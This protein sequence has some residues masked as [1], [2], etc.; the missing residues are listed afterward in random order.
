MKNKI[1]PVAGD[2]VVDRL[3]M[4]DET[5]AM[6]ATEC[7]VIIN[8]AASVNFDDP[9]LDAIQINYAGC[10]RMLE[11]AKECQH[12]DVFC[13][14]STAYTNSNK[15]GFISESIHDLE[16]GQDPDEL[17][18]GII[19]MGPQAV[20]DNE[21]KIIGAYPNTYTFT[22]SMAER[23]V[24][25]N[26]GNLRVAIV[27]PSIIVS[28]YDEPCQGWTD[29][30]AASGGIAYTLHAGLL[31]Y[32]KS[33]GA[34]IV[35]LIPC[36]FVTNM[37]IALSCYTAQEPTPCLNVMHA[38]TSQK[39]PLGFEEFG[40]Y[41]TALARYNPYHRQFSK[42]FYVISEDHNTFLYYT[43]TRETIPTKLVETFARIS[44]QTKL[45]KKA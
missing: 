27:R 19:K 40:K 44:G 45:M 36:D 29:T 7:D 42:P 2:L 9:L 34:G 35:D 4:N 3:G 14:V 1:V 21:K 16:G 38:A 22:K 18:Q 25:K 37:I 39:N 20:A 5:R 32:V 41:S 11:L 15:L 12:L 28:C 23:S 6:I 43:Y 13:H 26:R 17:I 31:H 30:V 24:K 33:T 10:K 8:C